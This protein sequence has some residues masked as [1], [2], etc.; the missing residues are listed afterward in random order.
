MFTARVQY[1]L[2]LL[3]EI[4]NSL[5]G[6]AVKLGELCTKYKLKKEFLIQTA[7]KLRL[8]GWVTIRKGPGGGYVSE[9][10]LAAVNFLELYKDMQQETSD[11]KITDCNDKAAKYLRGEYDR[12]IS[13]LNNFKV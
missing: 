12:F 6:E 13:K 4:R 8:T 1:A 9:K 10:D 11:L 5:P 2:L 7:R 3:K